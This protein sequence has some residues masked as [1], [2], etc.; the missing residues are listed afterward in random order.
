MGRLWSVVVAEAGQPALPAVHLEAPFVIGSSITARVR[1]PSAAAEPDHVRIEAGGQWRALAPIVG[2]GQSGEIGNG[3]TLAIGSYNVT[4]SPAVDGA[5]PTPPQRTESLARELMRSLLGTAGAPTLEIASGPLAGA[6][7]SLAPPDSTLVIGR[8]DEANWI[9]DDNDLSRAHAEVRRTLD[10]TTVKDLDSKNGT[11]VDG[12]QI[13]GETPLRDGSRVEL[14]K[15]ALVFRDP[16]EKH[17]PPVERPA[18]ARGASSSP[19]AARGASSPPAATRSTGAATAPASN[20]ATAARVQASTL[21][22]Y[23]A[24]A[25]MLVALAGLIW[26]LSS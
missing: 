4:L 21:P 12:E 11:K 9:I 18:T 23:A 20:A 25:I 14:G 15:L 2:D 7:R 26:V 13:D 1:L 22:F 24:I 19:A 3:V 8:G 17:L 16:A 6:K 5:A 10:G